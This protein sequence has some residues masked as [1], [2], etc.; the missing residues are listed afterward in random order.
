[1]LILNSTK[2]QIGKIE[3]YRLDND[4]NFF[5][6]TFYYSDVPLP[7]ESAYLVVYAATSNEEHISAFSENGTE[8]VLPL[9]PAG[10]FSL[11]A[12]Q[13]LAKDFDFSKAVIKDSATVLGSDKADFFYVESIDDKLIKNSLMQTVQLNQGKGFSMEPYII[14]R[15]VPANKPIKIKLVGRTHYGAPIQELLHKVY[16][17]NGQISFT[18]EKGKKYIVMGEMNDDVC[19]VWL[20]EEESHQIV[21]KKI[22]KELKTESGKSK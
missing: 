5:T 4:V 6:G 1:M 15:E 22:D 3:N 19:S 8:Y 17:V 14:D 16:E 18:P 9:A 11:T 13:P 20:E 2:Q 10:K 12:S 21:D 7:A